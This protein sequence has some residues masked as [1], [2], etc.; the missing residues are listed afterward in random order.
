MN[1]QQADDT[2]DDDDKSH[3]ETLEQLNVHSSFG[4]A[5]ASCIAS[6]MMIIAYYCQSSRYTIVRVPVQWA[7]RPLFFY[8]SR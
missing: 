8:V 1:D 3:A 7:R 6:I 2:F 5:C 4:L